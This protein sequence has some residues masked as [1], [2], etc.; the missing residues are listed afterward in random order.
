MSLHPSTPRLLHI[1]AAAFLAWAGMVVHN[2]ADL[3]IS[4]LGPENMLP[5][6]VWLVLLLVWFLRPSA[7]WPAILLLAWGS[8]NATGAVLT[9]LPLPFLPFAPEQSIRHYPFHGLYLLTQAPF[10]LIA[11]DEHFRAP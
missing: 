9:V 7:G 10:L 2:L 1:V 4:P 8:I 6:F 5:G 3:P 11:Y